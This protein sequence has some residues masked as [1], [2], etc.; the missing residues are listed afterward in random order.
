MGP[1]V[2]SWLSQTLAV[3]AVEFRIQV[4]SPT[5]RLAV[6]TS[7]ALACTLTATNVQD[8]TRRQAEVE[9]LIARRTAAAEGGR[10]IV[11]GFQ[12]DAALRVIRS[13]EPL[14]ALVNGLDRQGPQYWEVG[15]EGLT[16][17]TTAS[18]QPMIAVS[19]DGIDLEFVLRV[20]IGLL[21]VVVG[22]TSPVVSRS[23]GMT[24]SLV[25]L[26]VHATSLP[27]GAF[28]G[29]ACT[30]SLAA[31]IVVASATA[32]LTFLA[33][34]L[35]AGSAIQTSVIL[36]AIASLYG[37][38]LQGAGAVV[39][40][41]TS[42]AADTIAGAAS[43]WLLATLVALAGVGAIARG[44]A[45]VTTRA[46]FE[47]ERDAFYFNEAAELAVGAGEIVSRH[48]GHG[49][50]PVDLRIEGRLA[51]EM[52]AHWDNG[53]IQLRQQLTLLEDQFAAAES[54]QGQWASWLG[55]PFP[56]ALFRQAAIELAGVGRGAN[57]RWAKSTQTYQGDLNA[58]VFDQRPR[59]FFNLRGER[60]DNIR[61]HDRGPRPTVSELPAFVRPPES[62][63][64]RLKDARRAFLLLG[65]QGALIWLMAILTF[66]RRQGSLGDW[67]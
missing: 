21:A 12:R 64:A 4:R 45:P 67:R 50:A 59:V 52:N 40:L 10:H 22:A 6:F 56:G 27:A 63:W 60:G 32:T 14:S 33:P 19:S 17:G 23:G 2:T 1:V 61:F 49:L 41:V 20:L 46:L 24:K 43:V 13:P 57:M 37:V 11:G 31:A 58:A 7:I 26:P 29:G 66:A 8:F 30:I 53:L 5:C 51:Q 34:A 36:W 35:A 16:A 25:S 47:A 55:A 48:L 15:P 44:V 18:S 38:V 65:L 62:I 42:R 3:A 39:A 28:A 9:T 54:K